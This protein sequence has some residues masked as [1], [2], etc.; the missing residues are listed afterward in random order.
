MRL[1]GVVRNKDG[2][3]VSED[4]IWLAMRVTLIRAAAGL[5]GQGSPGTQRDTTNEELTSF[6]IIIYI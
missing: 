4:G 6:C 1:V 2:W 5:S 3:M